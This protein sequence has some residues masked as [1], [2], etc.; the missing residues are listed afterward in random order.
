MYLSLLLRF[1]ISQSDV[2]QCV[3]VCVLVC[4]SPSVGFM[5]EMA[6]VGGQIQSIINE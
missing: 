2:V 3:F 5:Q 6:Y 1:F 4:G